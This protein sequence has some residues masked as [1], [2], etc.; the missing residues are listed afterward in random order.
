MYIIDIVLFDIHHRQITQFLC[1]AWIYHMFMRTKVNDASYM[2]GEKIQ[3]GV[4]CAEETHQQVAGK[5]KI[6]T[7][8]LRGHHSVYII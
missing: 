7:H 1:S 2:W 4:F 3:R 5:P 8:P 6:L